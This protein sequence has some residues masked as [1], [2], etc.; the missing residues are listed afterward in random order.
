MLF[1]SSLLET[2]LTEIFDPELL[3]ARG[4]IVGRAG[5]RGE[6]YFLKCN[7]HHWVLRHYLRGGFIARFLHD[8]YLGFD[9]TRT[10]A[11]KEWYLL[12]D[13][14]ARGFAVPRPV[15]A[16]VRKQ[17]MLYRA[18][19]ITRCIEGSRPLASLLEEVPVSG[20]LWS[21]VGACIRVFHEAGVYHADLNANNILIDEKHHVYLIDFDRG[22]I[23]KPG[24]WAA[25][26]LGRL[27]RS[28]RKLK[29]L[30]S[31]FHFDEACWALLLGG[32]EGAA[33]EPGTSSR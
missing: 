5:G 18:D 15:A 1:D 13:L 31:P 7:G 23:R 11:W 16:R 2:G 4:Q 14:Y 17:G 24:T 12:A 9:V 3:E 22:E 32:Y 8:Q 29:G 10:R 25:A 33:Q 28:F 6:A 19:L 27:E 30:K 21:D 20:R 26:N